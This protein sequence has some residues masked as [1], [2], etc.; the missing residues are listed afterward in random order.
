MTHSVHFSKIS[1]L[2]SLPHGDRRTGKL[3]LEDIETVNVFRNRGLKTEFLPAKNKPEFLAHLSQI[4]RDAS[5]GDYP[6]LH[7]ECHGS[8]DQTGIVLADNSFVAWS[9]L[10]PFLTAI[11]VATRCNLF[12][13]LAACY[14][15]HLGQIILPTDRAP[16]WGIIGPTHTV[17]PD[18]LLSTFGAFYSEL[19]ASL[20]GGRSVAALFSSKLRFG[21]YYF[22]PAVGFFKLAYAKYKANYCTDVVLADRAKRMA[23][24]LPR[25]GSQTRPGRGALKRLLK[26][27]EETS[28]EKYYQQ[29]FM[30]DLFPENKKRFPLLLDE[31]KEL[32]ST[33]ISASRGTPRKC[34]AP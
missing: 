24:Q 13:I 10:K 17:Y 14:G 19:L 26:R 25:M 22:T 23:R 4:Q 21:A 1:I 31:V 8:T 30:M 16:C 6:L 12:I 15:G 33:L 9:E 2:E 7:I 18:E 20:D 27:T 11:N 29:F 34:G 28:Y 3:L 32:K 5:L